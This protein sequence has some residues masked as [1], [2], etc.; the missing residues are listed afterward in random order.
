LAFVNA[1][2]RVE[3]ADA[4][5]RHFAHLLEQDL[6]PVEKA[7]AQ[8]ILRER[9]QRLF[10]VFGRERFACQEILMDPDGA[11]DFAAPAIQRP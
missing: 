9:E 1:P 4:Q 6:R 8:I 10:P 11:F 7:G 5:A 2:Q 3:R